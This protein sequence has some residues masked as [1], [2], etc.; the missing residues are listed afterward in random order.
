[1]RL[2]AK[3]ALARKFYEEV[4]GW[5]FRDSITTM[6]GREED[7]N[8]IV[9]FSLGPTSPG[10]G[11]T[12]VQAE[13]FLRTQGKGSPVIYLMVDELKS[14]IEVSNAHIGVDLID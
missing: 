11:I 7:P 13:D 9:H 1:M 5:K 6:D 12:K 3:S 2:F 10:G 14:T 8:E 4:F